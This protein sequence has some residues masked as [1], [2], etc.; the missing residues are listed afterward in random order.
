MRRRE[1]LGLDL[2]TGTGTETSLG[3]REEEGEG[4]RR[5]R[6]GIVNVRPIFSFSLFVFLSSFYSTTFFILTLVFLPVLSVSIHCSHTKKK[7]K[8]LTSVPPPS[9]SFTAPSC[10]NH[11]L[12]FLFTLKVKMTYSILYDH[13]PHHYRFK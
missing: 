2:L 10:G 9:P 7:K 5:G 4:D 3:K 12:S 1:V 13:D 8:L 6:W 11:I